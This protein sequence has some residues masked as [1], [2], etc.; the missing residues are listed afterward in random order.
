VPKPDQGQV[1]SLSRAAAMLS[2]TVYALLSSW[3][4]WT[5]LQDGFG[6]DGCSTAA[7]QGVEKIHFLNNYKGDSLLVLMVKRLLLQDLQSTLYTR[8]ILV[9]SL[10]ATPVSQNYLMSYR[11]SVLTLAIIATRRMSE[12]ESRLDHTRVDPG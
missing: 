4:S 7:R 8:W 1:C 3:P 11:C 5:S 9:Q 2:N 12:R 10:A 6:G